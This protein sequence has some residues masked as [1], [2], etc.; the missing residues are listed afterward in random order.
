MIKLAFLLSNGYVNS[1]RNDLYYANNRIKQLQIACD[2][3]KINQ[4][5]QVSDVP[6]IKILEIPYNSN[7]KGTVTVRFIIKDVY[8]ENK[9]DDTCVSLIVPVNK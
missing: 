4:I 7:Y 5:I 8:K 2:E 3:L 6:D 1:L 9:Y